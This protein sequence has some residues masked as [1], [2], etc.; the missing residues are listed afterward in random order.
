MIR[1]G[2]GGRNVDFWAEQASGGGEENVLHSV[3]PSGR[4]HR[5]LANGNS[6]VTALSDR[7]ETD[8]NFVSQTNRLLLPPPPPLPLPL[9]LLLPG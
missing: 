8:V 6:D 1:F 7:A 5:W 9:L 3:S 2:A 4:C